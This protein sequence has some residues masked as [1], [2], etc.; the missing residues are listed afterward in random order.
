MDMARHGWAI[1]VVLIAL[2]GLVAI[3]VRVRS[4][5]SREDSNNSI[6]DYLLLWPVLL[7]KNGRARPEGKRNQILSTREIIGWVVVFALIIAAVVF[8]W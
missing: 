7:K 6:W 1:M 2:A 4:G 3:Y 5:L 8:G